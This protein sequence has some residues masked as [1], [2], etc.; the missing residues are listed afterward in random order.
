MESKA[1]NVQFIGLFL[2]TMYKLKFRSAEPGRKVRE[3]E[4]GLLR[5]GTTEADAVA[6][7]SWIV[8][9]AVG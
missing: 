2:S 3:Q 5:Y 1:T 4:R 6:P 7:V 8:F 9:V